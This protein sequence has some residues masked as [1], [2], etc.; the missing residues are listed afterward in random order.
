MKSLA[1]NTLLQN[2]YL[3]V[4]LIGKG[5]MGEVYLAVDQ[6][7]G[8][9]VALKR[10]LFSDEEA[11]GNAFEREAKML[12]RLRHPALTKVSDHFTEND[13]QYLVMEHISGEDLSKRLEQNKKPFPL[14]WV[15]FWA[16]QLL[17]ALTYLHS[18]EPPIIHRDIKPQN[19]KLTNENHIILLDFGLA[20]NAG[21]ETRLSTTGDVV[22][23]TP[24]YASMEQIRGTG[25][26]ARSD[27]YSLCATIYQLLT[28]LTPPDALTRADSVLNSLPD[29]V[30]PLHELNSEVSPAIAQVIA[31]GMSLSAEQRYSSAKEMQKALRE[32]YAQLQKG[33]SADTVAFN[34]ADALPNPPSVPAVK[35]SNIKTEVFSPPDLGQPIGAKTELMPVVSAVSPLENAV[36]NPDLADAPGADATLPYVSPLVF[37]ETQESTGIGEKTEVMPVDLTPAVGAKTEIMPIELAPSIGG[38]KRDVIPIDSNPSFGE[39]TELMPFDPLTPFDNKTEVVPFDSTDDFGAKTVISPIEYPIRTEAVTEVA[40]VGFNAPSDDKT[41]VVQID[42]TGITSLEKPEVFSEIPQNNISSENSFTT[43]DSFNPQA[44]VPLVNL[45]SQAAPL[46]AQETANFVTSAPPEN[47]TRETVSPLKETPSEPLKK[48]AGS[49][50]GGKTLIILG[51]LAIF[52]FLAIGVA[53]IGLYV[54]KP[55]LFTSATPTPAPTVEPTTKPTVEPTLS[56]TVETGNTNNNSENLVNSDTNSTN[57]GSN[58]DGNQN[59]DPGNTPRPQVEKTVTPN[60]VRTV[61]P[62][63]TKTPPPVKT[64]PVKTPP[65]VKQTTP[66]RTRIL[67]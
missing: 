35:Q 61:Q 21:G 39:K 54:L 28:N 19:L 62:Q 65:P 10:T 18:H 12:A 24:H 31:K 45:D 41:E 56:P 29:P 9:A 66:D 52:G 2:R 14:S 36:T 3:I 17:D 38:Q 13:T 47:L 48:A 34:V 5:G 25:T 63:T 44:T 49:G 32:A 46:P 67:P 4:Q 51:V 64:P 30:E 59:A 33:M 1:P 15:L 8:S 7:L 23:Y 27:I 42:V 50:G 53:G 20:K 60:P 40:P 22:A 57:T 58:T 26:T 55:E 43:A 16:D 37:K 6:R 11:L